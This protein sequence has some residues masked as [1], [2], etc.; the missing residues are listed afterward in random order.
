MGGTRNPQTADR[1]GDVE[2]ARPADVVESGRSPRRQ[3]HH[4]R[5]R[6]RR[7]RTASQIFDQGHSVRRVGGIED[8][9]VGDKGLTKPVRDTAGNRDV[10][11][12]RGSELAADLTALEG[13][14]VDRER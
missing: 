3:V 14:G 6:R 4:Q 7:R 5:R 8:P 11:L 13:V 9:D 12:I 1:S 2:S 10:V